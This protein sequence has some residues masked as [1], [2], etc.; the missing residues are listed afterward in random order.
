MA[1]CIAGVFSPEDA[2]KLIAERGRLMSAL[3]RDGEM[4][5]VFA[6][7]AQVAEALTP[8]LEQVSIAG[9]NGPDN[10]VISGSRESIHAIRKNLESAGIHTRLLSVSHAFHSPL[11]EP[12]LDTFEQVANQVRFEAPR[13]PLISNLTGQALEEGEIPG[14]H[15]WRRHIREAVQFAA[16]METLAELGYDLFLELGPAPTLLSL[17]K[18]CLPGGVGTWVPSLRKGKA[19]WQCMLESLGALYMRGVDVDWAGFDRDYQRHRLSLPT[20]PFERKHYWLDL[21]PVQNRDRNGA[22]AER[23]TFPSDNKVPLRA[24][25]SLHPLLG[26]RRPSALSMLQFESTIG[27]SAL[28]YLA[29]HRVHGSVVL[30]ATAYME[31][32]LAAAGEAFEQSKSAFQVEM[33]FQQ[34]LFLPEKGGRTV[35]LILYPMTAG[36]TSFQVFSLPAD[37]RNGKGEWTLHAAGKLRHVNA[38]RSTQVRPLLRELQAICREEVPASE[39]YRH[40]RESGLQYGPAFQGVKKLWR[41]DG[42]ALGQVELPGTLQSEAKMYRIHPALLDACIQ[43]VAGALPV[44]STYDEKKDAY[45]PIGM[46]GFQMYDRPGTRLWSYVALRPGMIFGADTLECDVYILNESGQGVAEVLGLRLA[47]PGH[48]QE[49][50]PSFNLNNWFYRVEWQPRAREAKQE[51]AHFQAGQAGSWLVFAD[52]TCTGQTL[53]A[54]LRAHGE[55]CF[56]VSPGETYQRSEQG[57]FYINP[58]SAPDLRQLLDET[59]LSGGP[60]C[61]GVLHFWSLDASQPVEA[62]TPASLQTV[63][64]LGSGYV[65]LLVQELVKAHVQEPPRLWLV[66]R[67]AQAVEMGTTEPVSVAQSPLWGLGR[68]IALEHP[69]LRCAHI[70]L[71]PGGGQYEVEALFQEL[72]SGDGDGEGQVAFRRGTRYVPRV[73]RVAAETTGSS[74]NDDGGLSIP[75]G[76]SFT[77]DIAKPGQLDT[78]RLLAAPRLEP[79]PGQLE[80]EVYAAGLNYRDVLNAMGVYPGDPIPLGAECAGKIVRLGKDVEG[81]RVGDEVIAVA[82]SSFGRFVTTDA[83]L[84][85]PK[86]AHLDFEEAATIPI[87]FLTA[88][89]ALNYLARMSRGE[90]VL[91]HAAAGGVG[92]SAVQLAQRA[93]A[94]VFATAG[95]PEKR[96]FLQYIGVRHVMDS[97][98]LAFTEEVLQRTGGK[99]VDIVLNS[100]PGEYIPKSLS[101]L[102]PHGRFLEI[103]K[104]DIYLNRALDLYPFSN[105]LSYFAIDLDRMCRERSSL[106]RSLF[107]EL[108]EYFNNGTL[109]PLPR[110]V[111]SIR[112]SV[113]AFR[114]LTQRKNIGKVVISLQDELTRPA[115]E[116]P[117]VIRSDATYL[118]TGGLGSLGLQVA[119]WLVQQGAR[120]LVLVGRRN[121]PPEARTAIAQMEGTGT[122]VVV[123]QTD[124]SR[125]EQVASIFASIDDTMPPLRGIIH[126][127]GV[128]DD[129]LLINLDRERLA[130]VMAPKVEGAWNLHTLTVNRPLD[131][132]VL[133]SSVASVLGSPGQGSYAA[134]NAF[135]D[136]LSHHRHALGL[137]ALTINWGPWGAA[138]MAAQANRG[139]RLATRGID[140]IAPQQGIEALEQLLSRRETGQVM[141]VS[142]NWQTLLESYSTGTEP[143]L[144]SELFEGKARVTASRSVRDADGELTLEVL[145]AA[146]QGQRLPMLISHLQKE[147][148]T[149]LGV[150]AVEID[151]Q[152]SLY[153]LGLDSLMALELKQ[154]LENGLGIALPIASLMQDPSL[155]KLSVQLLA[156]METASS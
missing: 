138:G 77:L 149:V 128:L 117:A 34:A 78:L 2:L 141:V 91:I 23:N 9:I 114:Y 49:R 151:P 20:S 62:M 124:V 155:N 6:S 1:A 72:L 145:S 37:E 143:A 73:S 120:N 86:P 30:P 82:P 100:L 131:F 48:G 64:E 19:E 127:A 83:S 113:E 15:Y 87:T 122:R 103:G 16:G 132:F 109:K 130:A 10:T 31:I 97:R 121:A 92:L 39:L 129:G 44:Q 154:R 57:H 18:T 27:T 118:I 50:M 55:T 76:P 99:G 125:K 146:E 24:P 95:N 79:G 52:S 7:E 35:Q 112:D 84:V 42:V 89:Y 33:T 59:L 80:I 102:A 108:M 137:P 12:I 148:S 96:A 93:G 133:F 26:W 94:E 142:A 11:M 69:E 53:A 135:L 123:A 43:V 111:S 104:M 150:E 5:A 56:I 38:A 139:R 147:L 119:Q 29:D 126:A 40:L 61:R 98:S 140:A 13:I 153:N 70:D 136:A 88:H 66:T 75:P 28:P 21:V 63:C 101:L 54:Q 105:S 51:L 90:R 156:L 110:Y 25:V 14:A 144:L 58:A 85:V 115:S 47:R 71:E 36:E 46:A 116:V 81:Y 65:L 134:A 60:P 106:I 32:V 152:E 17:G 45:L 68:V 107:L 41:G 8:F 4:M 74:G 3:P 67:G 22:G